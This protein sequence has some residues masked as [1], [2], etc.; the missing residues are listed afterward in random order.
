MRRG[1]AGLVERLL[2]VLLQVAI[3]PT[4]ESFSVND[5]MGAQESKVLVFNVCQG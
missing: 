5:E 2:E 4:R 1:D 3:T